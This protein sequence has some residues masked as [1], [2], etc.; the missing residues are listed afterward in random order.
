MLDEN[1]FDLYLIRHGQSEVNVFPDLMGQSPTVPLS[2]LGM[3]QAS[4]LGQ[5]F[6]KEKLQFG[7]VFSS[8]YKR[9]ID[10]ARLS[11]PVT[12][13]IIQTA[14]LREYSAGDWT[15]AKRSETLTI[16]VL[17]KMNTHNHHFLPPNGESLNQVERRASKWLEDEILYNKKFYNSKI[18]LFTHGMTIKCL[19]HYIMGFDKS[20][21]WKISIDNTSITHLSFS[22]VGWKLHS[23]N[24]YSHLK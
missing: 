11:V 2:D 15:G 8:T 6:Q 19:L 14:E 9:A 5:R 13:D 18:V 22:D 10:T 4:L 17:F 3:K 1:S 7:H 21:T 24:D 12:Q 16:D 20:F 23:I